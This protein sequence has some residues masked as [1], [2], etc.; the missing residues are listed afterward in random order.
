MKRM[1]VVSLLL[2][3]VAS[4]SFAGSVG[5]K[6]KFDLYKDSL[7]GRSFRLAS[8]ILDRTVAEIS[9]SADGKTMVVKT[10]KFGTCNGAYRVGD[11]EE[12]S[13][14]TVD[15][16]TDG[17]GHFCDKLVNAD[18]KWVFVN[19]YAPSSGLKTGSQVELNILHGDKWSDL[20]K[21]L[22]VYEIK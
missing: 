18:Y 17:A 8:P 11:A 10:E 15:I 2:N 7:A 1:L 14:N 3:L 9:F 13:R 5:Q 22:I 19:I 21:S 6:S 4:F 16:I 12:Y 20:D